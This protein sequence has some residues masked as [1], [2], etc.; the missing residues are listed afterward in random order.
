MFRERVLQVVLVLIGLAYLTAFLNAG[1]VLLIPYRG[2]PHEQMLSSVLGVLGI[3]LLLAV[4]EPS[5]HRSLIGFTAWSTVA[6]G[7][8]MVVQVMRGVLRRGELPIY[9]AIVVV[10]VALIFLVP[11]KQA[12]TRRA[13]G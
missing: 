9:V 12:G 7:G 3:F 5:A 8:V 10:G 6:H 11:G 2:E 4:R 13:A 1:Q